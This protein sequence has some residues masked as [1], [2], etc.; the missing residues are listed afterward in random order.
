MKMKRDSKKLNVSALTFALTLV[1]PLA[2]LLPTTSF[3]QTGGMSGGMR[4]PVAPP[5]GVRPPVVPPVAPPG[6]VVLPGGVRP[7]VVPPV[8]PPGGVVPPAGVI[9]PGGVVPPAGM[10]GMRPR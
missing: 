1:A 4:Q 7:P 2:I 5:G 8:A 10:P 9:P 6:G 3:A